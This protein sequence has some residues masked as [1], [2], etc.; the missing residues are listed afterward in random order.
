MTLRE[1]TA[2]NLTGRVREERKE[3]QLSCT[4]GLFIVVAWIL[5]PAL[6]FF[7][8]CPEVFF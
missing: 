6:H 4:E 3:R 8:L 1:I 2:A 7:M 5:K